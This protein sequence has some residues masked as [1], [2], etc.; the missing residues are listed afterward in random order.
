MARREQNQRMKKPQS[1]KATA[2]SPLPSGNGSD[3]LTPEI[4]LLLLKEPV[5]RTIVTLRTL[6][7]EADG[8]DDD[9]QVSL[10]NMA[11]WLEAVQQETPHYCS[12]RDIARAKRWDYK[13]RRQNVE[14]SEPGTMTH[15]KPKPEAA[16]PRRS[17]GSLR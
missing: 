6:A 13:H 9:T 3:A 8:L 10:W 11:L 12:A 4:K 2:S 16:N 7:D 5:R 14:A 1:S 15:D 17:P